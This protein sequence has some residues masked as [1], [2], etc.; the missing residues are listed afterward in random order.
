MNH[1][2]Q[3]TPA[4]PSRTHGQ[5]WE[6]CAN[7]GPSS[8]P[9]ARVQQVPDV[10]FYGCTLKRNTFYE[11]QCEIDN[12]IRMC[13]QPVE[14]VIAERHLGT[15]ATNMIKWTIDEWAAITC[16]AT[17]KPAMVIIHRALINRIGLMHFM[18]VVSVRMDNVACF[19]APFIVAMHPFHSSVV[20]FVCVMA[21]CDSDNIHR[22]SAP[23]P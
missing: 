2:G 21:R 23:I 20:C 4:Q 5:I 22:A 13:A 12:R 3:P 1:G 19:T 16:L 18:D 10:Q 7:D 11:D 15:L 9:A 6:T 14:R 8:E 17:I